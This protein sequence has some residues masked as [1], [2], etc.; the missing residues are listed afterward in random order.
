VLRDAAES[1]DYF[2]DWA[3]EEVK[4]FALAEHLPNR[5]LIV[6]TTLDPDLQRASEEAVQFFL[7]Q[8]GEQYNVSESAV[9]LIENNGAVR[10]MVGGRDYGESQFN[11]A[12]SAERQA[13]SSFKPYV[14]AA[15][16]EELGPDAG[17]V[18]RRRTDHL[19]R[20]VA[21]ELRPLLLRADE[22][23]RRHSPSRSTPC[24]SCWRAII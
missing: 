13:G 22:R 3:F 10:A 7:R 11:R 6:R 16:L 4:K 21:E 12:T 15:T 8:N 5:S 1:P 17:N 14:Y 20:L 9:V 18:V 24:R 19:A 23:W 2:L